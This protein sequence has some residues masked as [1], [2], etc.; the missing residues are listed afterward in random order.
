MPESTAAAS[1]AVPTT[2]RQSGRLG[3]IPI[4][5][6]TSLTPSSSMS[7]APGTAPGGRIIMPS[8]S[9]PSPSSFS[10]QSM[11][12]ET[13]PLI[14]AFLI[15]SPSGNFGPGG[16]TAP[17]FASA[18]LSPAF[19]LLAP[20]TIGYSASPSDTLQ[21]ESLSASGCL[22]MSSIWATTMLSR[23]LPT[24][25]IDS[26]SSPDIVSLSASSSAETE[27]STYSLSQFRD[28]IIV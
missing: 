26:T 13:C 17:A 25:S 16:R 8:D 22:P 28:I 15:V 20:Q 24:Y 3:V 4:S 19:M 27:K 12:S 18:T 23:A 10:A 5:R 11:P 14:F 9:I 2:L 7:R 21:R 6:R 1:L